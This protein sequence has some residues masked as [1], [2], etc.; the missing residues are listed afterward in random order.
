MVRATDSACFARRASVAA[1]RPPYNQGIATRATD[2]KVRPDGGPAYLLH[3]SG[4]GTPRLVITSSP[5]SGNETALASASASAAA[6]RT[7]QDAANPAVRRIAQN[8]HPPIGVQVQRGAAAWSRERDD[9]EFSAPSPDSRARP[10]R[11]S[12]RHPAPP[13]MSNRSENSSSPAADRPVISLPLPAG[14]VDPG[15]NIDDEG[16]FQERFPVPRA[17][18]PQSRREG[19]SSRSRSPRSWRRTG[20]G[21]T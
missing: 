13:V 16:G 18:P 20:S 3:S 5:R 7:P 21:G 12:R 15:R 8:D 9:G 19:G 1:Q 14:G 11:N 17:R 6:G 4:P 10:P 2:G